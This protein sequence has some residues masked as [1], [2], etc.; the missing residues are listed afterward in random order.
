MVK[1]Y[2]TFDL[3]ENIKNIKFNTSNDKYNR[4]KLDIYRQL[5]K[6]ITKP[7][8]SDNAE[9][10]FSTLTPKFITKYDQEYNAVY[11]YFINEKFK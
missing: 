8:I 10:N 3:K 2:N 5:R 11:A 6:Q 4:L 1:F 9:E 7:E